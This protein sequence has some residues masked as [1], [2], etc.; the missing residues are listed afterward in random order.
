MESYDIVIYSASWC[1]ACAALKRYLDSVGFTY[2]EIDT[3][4]EEGMNK[5]K[6]LNIRSLP[7]SVITKS[8]GDQTILIGP[9]KLSDIK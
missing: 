6:A 1:T 4:T 3:D 9:F 8:N 2:T 5:A 7:T